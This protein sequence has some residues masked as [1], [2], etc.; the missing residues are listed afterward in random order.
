L[1]ANYTQQKNTRSVNE[2]SK[3]FSAFKQNNVHRNMWQY[4]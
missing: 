3:I 4:R 2:Q 1:S